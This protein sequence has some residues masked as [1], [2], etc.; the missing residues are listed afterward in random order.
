MKSVFTI[1]TADYLDAASTM[2]ES[3]SM[4]N[5]EYEVFIF[6]ISENTITDFAIPFFIKLIDD[7]VVTNYNDLRK[8]YNNFELS[9]CLK[10]FIAKY[11][12]ENEEISKLIYLDSDIL[13]FNSFRLLDKYFENSDILLTPHTFQTINFDNLEPNETSFLQSG[14][15]NA[16]F[17]ALKKTKNT[18]NFLTWW[19]TRTS[20]YCII[21]FSKGLFVDQIWLNLVPLYFKNVYIIEHLG[22]NVSYW[23]LHE[24]TIVKK[25]EFY[26]VND[27]Y[28]LIFFHLSGFDLSN[29]NVISKYQNRFEMNN[30]EPIK[31][32]FINYSKRV[33][34]FKQKFKIKTKRNKKKIFSIVNFLNKILYK[35]NFKLEKLN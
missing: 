15:Y 21:N 27:E 12:F 11:L 16:G 2:L 4:H 18:I 29:L 8:K 9:C 14:L 20:E 33:I 32:I 25:D 30:L 31:Q 17:F 35:V 19:I 1:C 7:K 22:F 24:R 23:N 28:E 6:L 3:F 5:K 34:Y 10:P 26:F 13:I